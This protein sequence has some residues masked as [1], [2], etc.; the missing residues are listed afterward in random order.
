MTVLATTTLVPAALFTVDKNFSLL[1]IRQYHFVPAAP[2]ALARR[3]DLP[4]GQ[5]DVPD[6]DQECA[7][8]SRRSV[9]MGFR[10]K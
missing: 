1:V 8:K 5:R 6:N 2:S 10:Q 9:S 4:K 7:G 3:F